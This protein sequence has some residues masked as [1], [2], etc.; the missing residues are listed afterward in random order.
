LF[1]VSQS[2]GD[3]RE[4]GCAVFC[5]IGEPIGEDGPHRFGQR[6]Q[7][8]LAFC[9]GAI[10][11][12]RVT[13]GGC[14]QSLPQGQ[15]GAL[16]VSRFGEQR[17]GG[18][19]LRARHQPGEIGVA[20]QAGRIVILAAGCAAIGQ[21]LAGGIQGFRGKTVSEVEFGECR[22]GGAC[23]VGI[24]DT[25]AQLR[26]PFD[27]GAALPGCHVEAWPAKRAGRGR[28]HAPHRCHAGGL[29]GLRRPYAGGCRRIERRQFLGE[30]LTQR[31]EVA[32][33]RRCE[34]SWGQGDGTVRRPRGCGGDRKL[35]RRFART[36]CV[37]A[38]SRRGLRRGCGGFLIGRR[39]RRRTSRDIDH[40]AVADAKDARMRAG[41]HADR[42][43]A[44]PATHAEHAM[45][46]LARWRHLAGAV[47]LQGQSRARLTAGKTSAGREADRHTIEI[48]MHTEA[49]RHPRC[50][51][52]VHDRA[53]GKPA[54]KPCR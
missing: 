42:E 47:E 2:F 11:A 23:G 29:A 51:C 26:A 10:D 17:R 41:R 1:I 45:P 36:C 3:Q 30:F 28:C 40:Q 15:I 16:A 5:C 37:V 38:S 14:G 21:S 52:R 53:P 4:G 48:I 35:G 20:L 19:D 44:F 39:C 9:H 18:G 49:R 54:N 46:G 7:R 27:E 34:V 31:I 6:P 22:Q 24:C 50:V 32:D 13:P 12:G 43:N 25:C 33:R 8:G